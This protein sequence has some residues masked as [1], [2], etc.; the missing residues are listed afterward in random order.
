MPSERLPGASERRA[1]FEIRGVPRDG[2]SPPRGRAEERRG[3]Y[4]FISTESPA[5]GIKAR[6]EGQEQNKCISI[7]IICTSSISDWI[8]GYVTYQQISRSAE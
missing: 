2:I 6:G 8:R 3:D 7:H 1:S 5:L 4:E